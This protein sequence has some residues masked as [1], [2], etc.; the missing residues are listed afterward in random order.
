MKVTLQIVL[1]LLKTQMDLVAN[2]VTDDLAMPL[3]GVRT[4]VM[5]VFSERSQ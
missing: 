1:A 3:I 2:L 4:M 5:T